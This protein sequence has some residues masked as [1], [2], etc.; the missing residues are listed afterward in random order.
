MASVDD[1]SGDPTASTT[2]YST[3]SDHVYGEDHRAS[4]F[5]RGRVAP[6]PRPPEEEKSKKKGKREA[7]DRP[8]DSQVLADLQ[9]TRLAEQGN[10]A[11]RQPEQKPNHWI[12]RLV[13][14]GVLVAIIAA[15]VI[16]GVPAVERY[17]TTESTDDAFVSGHTTYVS[18]RVEGLVTEVMV[19]ENDRVVPGTLLAQL[20][21]E[22]FVIALEQAEASLVQARANLDLSKA[23]VKSQL[24]SARGAYF[25]RKSQQE[26]LSRL[27]RSLESQ[28]ATLRSSQSAQHLAE[29]DQ[30]G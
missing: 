8:V 21:R 22:P 3:S 2:V 28:V 7:V 6:A 30:G 9:G 24:A 17:S 18:P 29:L 19:E 13:L 15:F 20:D 25:Q 11:V 10:P 14:V 27:I 1:V 23:S 4:E 5:P 26:Q 16:W 12:G